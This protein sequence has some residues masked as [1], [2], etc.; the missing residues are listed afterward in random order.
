DPMGD[1]VAVRLHRLVARLLLLEEVECL[2][3]AAFVRNVPECLP[4][5]VRVDAAVEAGRVRLERGQDRLA[6][7]GRLLAAARDVARHLL[8][9]LFRELVLERRHSPAP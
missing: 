1:A 8:D 7:P 4:P 2:L 6:A 3:R 9:L 5:A